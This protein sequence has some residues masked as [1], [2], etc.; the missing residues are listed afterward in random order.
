MLAVRE[1]AEH[2]EPVIYRDEHHSLF[3]IG[4]AV[5]LRLVHTASRETAAVYEH[6]D[7]SFFRF[8]GGA[9]VQDEAVLAVRKLHPFAEFAVI[10]PVLLIPIRA[11]LGTAHA[12]FGSVENSV[13]SQRRDGRTESLRFGVLHPSENSHPV[14]KQSYDFAARSLNAHLLHLSAPL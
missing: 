11:H 4:G 13:I 12:L 2:I 14:R 5:E 3:R 6:D 7:G 10:K 9:D 1:K 8:F